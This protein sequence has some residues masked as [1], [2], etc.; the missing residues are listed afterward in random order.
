MSEEIE[1]A[2]EERQAVPPET[3]AEGGKDIIR[4][5]DFTKLDL[6]IGRIMEVADH[7]NADRLLVLKVDMGGDT[8]QLVAGIRGD[9][10]PEALLEREIVVV[11]NLAP[12]KV[13][14]LESQGMLIAAVVRKDDKSEVVILTTEKQVPPGSP[15]S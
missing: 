6:R 1:S 2:G 12:R 7:P 14:G 8:R 3:S 10:P 13:R 11:A 15:C 5:E 9:Y 4:Y